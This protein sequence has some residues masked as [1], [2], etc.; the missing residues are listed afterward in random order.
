[1]KRVYRAGCVAVVLYGLLAGSVQA[2][3]TIQFDY[4]LDTNGFF[5]S[6]R[7]DV[8]ETA[9]DVFEVFLDD[10]DPITPGTVGNITNTWDAIFTHPTSG[11]SHM[12][13]DMSVPADTLIMFAGARNLAGSTLGQG[14]PGGFS[15]SGTQAF[16]D[17]VRA[18]GELGALGVDPTLYTDFGP[19]GGTIAFDTI[20]A[21]TGQNRNW[22]SDPVNGPGNTEDDLL[23]VAIHEL[24][25]ALGFG[26]VDSWINLVDSANNDFDGPASRLANNNTD[27]GLEPTDLSHWTTG[28]LD[29][30]T[31]D[32]LA[33]DPSLLR[34]ERKLFT[35]LDYAGLV[36][37]GWEVPEPA[38]LILV[39]I[40]VVVLMVGRRRRTN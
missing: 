6:Q 21:D 16:V 30:A 25:H 11:A 15:S 7:M 28:V 13:T 18:R 34:G 20:D 24:A 10:L 39:G 9:A 23:S 1:M 33:M 2:G 37:V 35:A 40:G 26:T 12:I 5:T 36:D 27:P 31:G 19:W 3:I 8:L 4:S 38:T 14:G 29:F 32:E 17:N 22:N